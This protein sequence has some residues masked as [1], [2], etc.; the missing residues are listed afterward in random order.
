MKKRNLGRRDFLKMLGLTALGTAAACTAPRMAATAS[1]SSSPLATDT[2]TS[3]P[4]P[5]TSTPT[6]TVAPSPVPRI[7]GE[8]KR[9]L[10]I[11][12]MTDWH[13]QPPKT[14]ENGMIRALHHAQ[15]Q[16]DPPDIIFNTGDSVMDSLHTEKAKVEAEWETFKGILSTECKLPIVHAIGN[17]DVW[18]WGIWDEWI[19]NDPDYGKQMALRQLGLSSPYYSFDQAG[20]HFIVLDSIHPRNL[21]SQEHYIGELDEEQRT[22]LI[23]DVQAVSQSGSTPICILRHIPIVSVCEYFYGPNEQSGNWV[24]PASWMHLDA[25]SFRSLFLQ[26]PNIKLCLSGHAHQYESL[27]YMGVRYVCSGAVSGGW[28]HGTFMSFPPAYVMVNLYSNGT[29]DSELVQY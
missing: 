2:A 24:V 25:R 28:W 9:V 5:A 21:V 26:N 19:L 14:A 23:N 20:W 27:D 11:A 13:M 17:H 18:A 22:W 15:Q 12:H 7:Q 16:P 10:R 4:P 29:A 1:P 8:S 6:S 3:T